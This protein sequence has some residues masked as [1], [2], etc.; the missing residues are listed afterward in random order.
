[1]PISSPGAAN[2]R[3]EVGAALEPLHSAPPNIRGF[4]HLFFTLL[5]FIVFAPL[6]T[7]A[8]WQ[9]LVYLAL[10]VAML[11]AAFRLSW[12]QPKLRFVE[13]VLLTVATVT[14]ALRMFDLK[15]T[16]VSSLLVFTAVFLILTV[17]LL[18]RKVTSDQVVT[19]D[20]L[21]GA[22][23]IYLLI[24]ITWALIFS[25]LSAFQQDT[26]SYASSRDDT[27][28]TWP[29]YLYFSFMTLATVG[30][31]DI[32]PTTQ[33]ARSVAILEVVSGVFYVALLIGRLVDLY[34]SKPN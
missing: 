17:I 20:T 23:S 16:L 7:G 13:V 4:P 2:D 6:A 22:A 30:Y 15:S 31:G 3:R 10:T 26:L 5:A 33:I 18:L 11:S 29:S 27:V 32:T 8:L 24:G 34:R 21:Y 14:A 9:R 12:W 19:A 25:V 28:G 1:M